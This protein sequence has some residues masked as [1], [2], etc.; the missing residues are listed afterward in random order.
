MRQAVG[1]PEAHVVDRAISEA[2]V[3]CMRPRYALRDLDD[4]V[5]V[6][7]TRVFR[8]ATLILVKNGADRDLA[9]A[10]IKSRLQPR[11]AHSGASNVPSVRMNDSGF[12]PAPRRRG[13]EWGQRDRDDMGRAAAPLDVTAYDGVTQVS[14]KTEDHVVG[15]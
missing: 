14:P 11:R 15:E 9:Q 6:S 8:I 4:S 1:M 2:L 12:T 3:F 10:A 5:Y 7:M 13:L